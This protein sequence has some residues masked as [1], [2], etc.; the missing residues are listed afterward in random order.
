MKKI[1]STLLLLAAVS[2]LWA[3][4]A[5]E[6]DSNSAAPAEKVSLSVLWFNDGN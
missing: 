6:N 3:N 2:M 4:G 1:L 5:K